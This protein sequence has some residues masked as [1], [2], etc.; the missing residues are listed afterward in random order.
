MSGQD[1]NKTVVLIDHPVG[2][3]DD[4]ASRA[5]LARGY[6][7]QWVCAGEGDPL[8]DP[9][10]EHAAAIVYGGP[11]S[12]NDDTDK[13]YIGAELTWIEAWLETEKPFLG[14]CLGG[15]MLA[16]VLGARVEPHPEDLF[17]IGYVP[18]DPAPTAD[19]FLD[20]VSHVYHWHKEGFDIPIGSELLA[21]GQVFPNQ[22]FRAGPK[23]YGLQF[24][25]EVTVPVMTRWMTEAAHML[26]N[27]NAHTRER[28][29]ADAEL[30]DEKMALWLDRFLDDWLGPTV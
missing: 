27:P 29:L 20:G 19:G 25:P 4:R 7:L 2:K 15:Q 16:R 11:E 24:H 18:I 10:S 17:E 3:R 14:L 30:H 8:P 21:L 26:E 22:A 12:A 1:D 5:L 28:Q 9:T 23:V 13:P 6:R